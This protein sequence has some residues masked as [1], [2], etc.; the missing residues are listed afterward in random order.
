[1]HTARPLEKKNCRKS[2][3][4]MF[5]IHALQIECKKLLLSAIATAVIKANKKSSHLKLITLITYI[6]ECWEKKYVVMMFNLL[7]IPFYFLEIF[8]NN[9]VI[10]MMNI[11]VDL[12]AL[13]E[14]VLIKKNKALN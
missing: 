5:F 13:F 10:A 14:S 1:M 3:A 2:R 6:L 7:F 4:R 12:M 8:I 9:S 11:V